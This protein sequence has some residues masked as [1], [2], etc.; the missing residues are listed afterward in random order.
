MSNSGY[1]SAFTLTF[2]RKIW[3]AIFSLGLLVISSACSDPDQEVPL[4]ITTAADAAEI[5]IAQ[6][7]DIPTPEPDPATATPTSPPPTPT[8]PLAALVNGEMITKA[9]YEADLAQFTEEMAALGQTLPANYQADRLNQLIE[10]ALI[11]QAAADWGIVVTDEAFNSALDQVKADAE[12]NG[13]Y[14]AWLRA[15]Q[16]TADEFSAILREQLLASAV[17]E[18]VVRSVPA[19]AE[20]ARGR[21]IVVNDQAQAQS[22]L[23]QA[24]GGANFADLAVINSLDQTTAPAGGDLGFIMRGW[25]F[26]P[27]IEELIFSLEPN[28]IS[29]VTPVDF[30]NGQISYYIVQALEKDP[31]RPLTTVQRD[32]MTKRV[33]EEW[34]G[35]RLAS[36]EIQTFE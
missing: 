14:E 20:Q 2:N 33:I 22:L 16:Y 4:G 17:I 25:L 35:E 1:F 13:G 18:Q 24:R 15:N 28:Q 34:L 36:A 8:P 19:T 10:S 11:R 32:V 3:F 5:A 29:E 31:E 30:G 23:D 12:S 7:T 6:P 27:E 26:R 21:Y 9:N